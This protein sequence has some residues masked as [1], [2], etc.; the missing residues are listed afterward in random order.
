[1][2][3]TSPIAIVLAAGKCTR[4]N[5]DLPKV[6]HEAAGKTLLTWVLDALNDAGCHDQIVVIGYRGESV[7]AHVGSRP[8]V[9]LAVQQK[10]LGTGDAVRA[11]APLIKSLATGARA[12]PVVIVCGDGAGV[13]DTA[14]F[15]SSMLFASPKIPIYQTIPVTKPANNTIPATLNTGD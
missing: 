2:H 3:D 13:I 10:Q 8:G 7:R 15:D 6:L 11:A 9:Q 1:M 5:S 12:R 4:M 14:E